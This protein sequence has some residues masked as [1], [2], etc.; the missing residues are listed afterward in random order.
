MTKVA[1]SWSSGKD[2]AFLLGELRSTD[3]VE[4]AGLVTTINEAADRV[5]M[6]AVRRELLR[7]QAAA[8]GLPIEVVPLPDP[9]PNDAYEAAMHAAFARLRERGVEAVAHGDLHLADVRDYRE[10]LMADTGLEPL[11]PL[12]G[13]DTAALARRMIE[14]GQR[15][16][17]TCVDTRQLG[18]EFAGREFDAGF[19]ADLPESVDPCGENGEFHTFVYDS[20]GFREALRV[21]RGK[22]VERDGFLYT[23][24][25]PDDR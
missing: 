20:P 21:V 19:L 14:S 6:H 12:W 22:T 7:Y 13:R 23:D 24:L 25:L 9:C 3:G 16:I 17:V 11:F 15:A 10:R 4:I 5:A 18:R 1:V 2:S 8:L